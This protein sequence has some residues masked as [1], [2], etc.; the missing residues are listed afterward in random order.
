MAE[1]IAPSLAEWLITNKTIRQ[2]CF[3]LASRTEINISTWRGL[4]FGRILGKTSPQS[5]SM[6]IPG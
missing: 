6:E 1:V 3:E 4:V 2:T 5:M